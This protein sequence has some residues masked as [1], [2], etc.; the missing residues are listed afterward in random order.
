MKY[1]ILFLFLSQI[2]AENAIF[3]LL[4]YIGAD[5]NLSPYAEINI[6]DM[7][8]NM[9]QTNKVN[10][11]IQWDQPDNNKT[12]RYKIIPNGRIDD[13]SLNQ[14]MGIYPTKEIINAMTWVKQKHPANH[15]GLFLWNHGSGVED[16]TKKIAR[17]VVVPGLQENNRGILYDDSQETCLT[18]SGLSKALASVKKILGQN[19][20]ILGMDACLM[21]MIEIG[22]Q[23]KDYV[24]LLVASEEV[25]PGLGWPYGLFIAPLTKNPTLFTPDLLA[26]SI[27]TAYGNF[28][29]DEESDVCMSAIYLNKINDIKTNIDQLITQLNTCA[30]YSASTIK[31]IVINARL[32]TQEFAVDSYIDLYSF[33]EQLLKLINKV[34]PK[35]NTKY[36]RSLS[37]IKK[38]ISNGCTKI[39]NAILINVAGSSIPD[40]HGISIYYPHPYYSS[41]AIHKSYLQTQF[42]KDTKWLN[43]IKKYRY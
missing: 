36:K 21:A 25:E 22:Y 20:D 35:S 6:T 18:N 39:K 24:N 29:Q 3:S 13:G 28:Y 2:H 19:L 5:N 27:V 26:K 33:Y 11:L 9:F 41:T 4:D 30:K 10:L 17:W 8:K 16:Y 42:A 40:A 34:N 38:T 14:E 7:E 43:F 12:W 31:N 15:Y 37:D 32:N 1:M 23:V